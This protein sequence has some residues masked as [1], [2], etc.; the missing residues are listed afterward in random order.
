[1][2]KLMRSPP[3][4]PTPVPDPVC[5][6]DDDDDTLARESMF[7]VDGWVGVAGRRRPCPIRLVTT[8]DEDCDRSPALAEE[9]EEIDGR[10]RRPAAAAAAALV[11]L[12][13]RSPRVG[14]S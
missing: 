1:M 6:C 5:C 11:G 7:S 4:P 2:G 13:A 10:R 3:P 9:R 12:E 14:Y 8:Y